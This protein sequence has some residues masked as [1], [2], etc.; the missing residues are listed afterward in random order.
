MSQSRTITSMGRQSIP[1][2]LFVGLFF[3][4]VTF[5]APEVTSGSFFD[6]DFRAGK[7]LH[8][9]TDFHTATFDGKDFHTAKFNGRD[10]H[11]A[12]FDG[13]FHTAKFNDGGFRTAKFNG[14]DFRTAKFN[15]KDFH[16]AKFNGR[17]FLT[18][19]FDG[20]DFHTA[21]FN[22]PANT[23]NGTDFLVDRVFQNDKEFLTTTFN[24]NPAFFTM[25]DETSFSGGFDVKR[26]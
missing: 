8:V 20:R 26:G 18:A 4:S 5:Q 15:S 9:D 23:F 7:A 10:F 13:D 19:T 3:G 17:D 11:T 12:T 21:T 2:L 16:T 14:R 1:L 25:S 22:D 6:V 24:T